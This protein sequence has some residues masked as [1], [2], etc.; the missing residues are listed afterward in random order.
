[1]KDV[2]TFALKNVAD[3]SARFCKRVKD[4]QIDHVEKARL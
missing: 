4:T 1:M 2:P 3:F